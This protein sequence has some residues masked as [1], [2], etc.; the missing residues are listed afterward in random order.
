[1]YKVL[2]PEGYKAYD[3]YDANYHA[4]RFDTKEQAYGFA[5][6][7]LHYTEVVHKKFY[8][9]AI[10]IH[11]LDVDNDKLFRA[12]NYKRKAFEGSKSVLSFEWEEADKDYEKLVRLWF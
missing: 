6:A 3:G 12:T 1:M 11:M 8:A 9:I 5:L 2:I 7:A 10:D 4:V